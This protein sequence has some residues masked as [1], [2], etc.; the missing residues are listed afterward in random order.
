MPYSFATL[1]LAAGA[2]FLASLVQGIAGFGIG[3]V[4]LPLLSALLPLTTA[5]P[6][7]ILSGLFSVLQIAV[8][9]RSVIRPKNYMTLV[10]CGMSASLL[11]TVLLATSDQHTI[12][13]VVGP[14]IIFFGLLMAFGL[15][16]NNEKDLFLQASVGILAGLLNGTVSL[17]GPPIVIFLTGKGI[18]KEEFKGNLAI[19]VL[20]FGS[21][22]LFF[23]VL[24]GI[25]TA[26]VLRI[27]LVMIVPCMAGIFL[28]GRITTRLTADQFRWG[29]ILLTMV[30]GVVLLIGALAAKIA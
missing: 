6:L 19:I 27:A 2:I 10:L 22:T 26:S 12:K 13:L 20:I 21:T 9:E 15:R 18:V 11:G 24:L 16:F 25:F 8:A 30:T 23:Q 29:S 17:P 7:V 3:L 14:A 5:V 28:G 4:A 1:A